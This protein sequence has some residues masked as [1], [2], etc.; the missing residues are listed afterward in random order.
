MKVQTNLC[1]RLV[2]TEPSQLI[3]TKYGLNEDL[4]QKDIVYFDWVA[5]PYHNPVHITNLKTEFTNNKIK[6]RWL[7]RAVSTLSKIEYVFLLLLL[8]LFILTYFSFDEKTAF[9]GSA[10]ELVLSL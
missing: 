7:V 8:L 6:L 2:S 4:A 1:V 3:L 10:N 5:V 9:Y